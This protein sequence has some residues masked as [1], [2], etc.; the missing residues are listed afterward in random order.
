MSV[1]FSRLPA[2]H[3]TKILTPCPTTM[4]TNFCLTSIRRLFPL[5]KHVPA[6]NLPPTSPSAD[7]ERSWNHKIPHPINRGKHN[8]GGGWRTRRKEKENTIKGENKIKSFP[9]TCE[10]ILHPP[11]NC[12]FQGS[13][14]FGCC[15]IYF[16]LVRH[17]SYR[18]ASSVGF[19]PVID[20]ANFPMQ[21]SPKQPLK[22]SLTCTKST[23]IKHFYLEHHHTVYALLLRPKSHLQTTIKSYNLRRTLLPSHTYTLK[24]TLGIHTTCP[25][26]SPSR[27]RHPNAQKQTVWSI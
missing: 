9:K 5:I 12:N 7:P 15:I 24:F 21:K 1:L 19:A 18:S 17:T 23:P 27:T 3:E 25:N 11:R 6:S 20:N 10:V 16:I 22:A 8:I 14:Q 13:L 2:S 4:A 26:S